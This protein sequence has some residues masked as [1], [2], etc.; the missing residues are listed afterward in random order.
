MSE[1]QCDNRENKGMQ[2]HDLPVSDVREK[3]VFLH[4]V[5]ESAQDGSRT[6]YLQSA[7]VRLSPLV[8]DKFLG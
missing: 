3:N 1:V 5:H 2:V 8:A 4:G 7:R 6:A